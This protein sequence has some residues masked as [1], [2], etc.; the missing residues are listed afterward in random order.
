MDSLREELNKYWAT[1]PRYLKVWY[2]VSRP[3][4]RFYSYCRY[5][6][7]QGIYGLYY[8]ARFAW[9]WRTWDYAYGLRALQLHLKAL[10][11]AL[12]HGH[13]V[14]GERDA[15]QVKEALFLIDR[16]LE[17][18]WTLDNK[19]DCL[20]DRQNIKVKGD[21]SRRDMKRLGEVLGKHMLGW[22]D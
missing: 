8:W 14:N 21:Q 20:S 1:V 18:D 3:F 12:R 2:A 22:W 5:D 11:P 7:H 19:A 16:I 13:H 9:T 4:R 17:D 10:E 15:D 6:I